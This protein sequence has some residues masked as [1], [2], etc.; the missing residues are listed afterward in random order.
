[1]GKENRRLPVPTVANHFRFQ[2]RKTPTFKPMKIT[3]AVVDGARAL[4]E[5]LPEVLP[6]EASPEENAPIYLA[7]LHFPL[8]VAKAEPS[9][10]GRVNLYAHAVEIGITE[11]PHLLDVAG[12]MAKYY[13]S[14]IEGDNDPKSGFYRASWMP[15]TE[16]YVF[17]QEGDTEDLLNVIVHTKFPRFIIRTDDFTVIPLEP[18][19]DIRPHLTAARRAYETFLTESIAKL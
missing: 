17:L 10:C 6:G 5:Q 15:E 14:E 13:T 18:C 7:H 8:V 19:D 11:G 9:P 16:E 3:Q 2:L 12:K 4:R 1:M